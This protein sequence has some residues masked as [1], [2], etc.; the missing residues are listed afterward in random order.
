MTLAKALT[1]LHVTVL[2]ED[3]VSIAAHNE[4]AWKKAK[5]HLRREGTRDAIKV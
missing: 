2:P 5:F 4:A 3:G 1:H